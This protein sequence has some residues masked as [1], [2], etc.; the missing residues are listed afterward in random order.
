MSHEDKDSNQQLPEE[1]E[2]KV[3]H[4]FNLLSKKMVLYLM[5]SV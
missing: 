1:W 5:L 4:L 2:L 3:K